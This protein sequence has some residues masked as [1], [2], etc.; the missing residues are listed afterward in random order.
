[1][2]KQN[3]SK[4]YTI[5]EKSQVNYLFV[6]ICRVLKLPYLFIFIYY[7]MQLPSIQMEDSGLPLGPV[8][9][10]G[11]MGA[12]APP[13][14]GRSVNPISTKGGILCPLN[15]TGTPGFSDFP[16]ALTLTWLKPAAAARWGYA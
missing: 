12:L 1:M 13:H 8:I 16:T 6:Y 4:K 7:Y 5:E 9:P 10:G 3:T 15:N 14:F 2:W 11:A